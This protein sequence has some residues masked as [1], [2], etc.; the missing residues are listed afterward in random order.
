MPTTEETLAKVSGA[1]VVSKLDANSG[2]WQRKLSEDSKL[3]TTFITPWGR[4][5]FT[6]LPFGVSSAPEHFQK[7]MERILERLQGVVCQVDDILLF[8]YEL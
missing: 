8:V 4:Y 3:L 5:C 1:K 7:S 2:F 6:R